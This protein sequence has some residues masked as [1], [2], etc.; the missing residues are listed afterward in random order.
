MT[1]YREEIREINNL[2]TPA[3]WV[4]E[5]EVYGVHEHGGFMALGFAPHRP[6]DCRLIAVYRSAV[7]DLIEAVDAVEA[8]ARRASRNAS[9]PAVIGIR[10]ILTI[11]DE[12]S[13]E[14]DPVR[15]TLMDL[16]S[17]ATPPP[18]D[19]GHLILGMEFDPQHESLGIAAPRPGDPQLIAVARIA[20]PRALEL[21]AFAEENLTEY[22]LLD[23]SLRNEGAKA[24]AGAVTAFDEYRA[25]EGSGTGTV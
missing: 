3:P 13:N 9:V 18:W 1:T 25:S 6:L 11:L 14:G 15:R 12:I 8:L 19:P 16:D 2:A 17:K 4:S 5:G 24:I 23:G 10:Q 22:G 21:L 20:V 7:I